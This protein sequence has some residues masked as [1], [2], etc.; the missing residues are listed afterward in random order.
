MILLRQGKHAVQSS[1]ILFP[2]KERAPQALDFTKS[3]SVLPWKTIVGAILY[4]DHTFREFNID[5]QA[6]AGWIDI[7]KKDIQI[8]V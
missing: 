6:C 4:P 3:C 5:Y 2:L 1:G 7:Q 8:Q